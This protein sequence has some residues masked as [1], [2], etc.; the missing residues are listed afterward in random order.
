M[1]VFELFKI[2]VNF[3][4]FNWIIDNTYIKYKLYIL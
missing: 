1:L 3:I 2:N 4:F